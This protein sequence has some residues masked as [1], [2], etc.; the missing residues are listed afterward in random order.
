MLS[1]TVYEVS[2]RVFPIFPIDRGAAVAGS[3]SLFGGSRLS[4]HSL[5]KPGPYP[6]HFPRPGDDFWCHPSKT[7]KDREKGKNE[8]SEFLVLV[9]AIVIEE[10]RSSGDFLLRIIPSDG[11]LHTNK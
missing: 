6:L 9:P 2:V 8:V 4:C 10:N 11:S 3:W 5:S 7:G 1:I